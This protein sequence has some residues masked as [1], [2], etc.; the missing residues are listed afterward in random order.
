M[1]FL[2]ESG[3]DFQPGS[4]TE[5]QQLIGKKFSLN[6]NYLVVNKPGLGPKGLNKKKFE[7]SFR[8]PMRV[9]DARVAIEA[10]IPP[11][12]QIIL[13]GYSEGAYLAPDVALGDSRVKSVVLIGGGTR[14][15]LKEELSNAKADSTKAVRAEIREIH[16][17]PRSLREWHGFSY[18]TWYSYRGDDTFDA[19]KKLQAPVLAILG[20]RDRTIDFKS[21]LQDLKKLRRHKKAVHIEVIKKCGHSFKGHWGTVRTV[22]RRHLREALP[23]RPTDSPQQ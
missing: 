6:F 23:A 21:T 20:K 17:H 4:R 8:R 1:V 18:A 11:G 14:G 2:Q 16:K 12:A 13:M 5:L 7:Q 15:W 19:L 22:L 9:Q 3:A 10:A